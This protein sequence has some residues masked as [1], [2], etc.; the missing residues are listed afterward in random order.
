[1]KLKI[2]MSFLELSAF[3]ACLRL[4]MGHVYIDLILVIS[5]FGDI[6]LCI[7]SVNLYS[8][9]LYFRIAIIIIM[10]LMFIS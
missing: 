6:F 9:D 10:V 7:L 5:Y 2:L 1:M 8:G 3:I 4:K